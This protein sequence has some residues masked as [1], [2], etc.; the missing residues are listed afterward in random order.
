MNPIKMSQFEDKNGRKLMKNKNL[1]GLVFVAQIFINS[2][3]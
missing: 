3:T 2:I 1:A